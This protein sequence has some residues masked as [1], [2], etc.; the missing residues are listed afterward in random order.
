VTTPEHP[1]EVCGEMN[2]LKRAVGGWVCGTCKPWLT[3]VEAAAT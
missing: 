3:T 1:C 2:W